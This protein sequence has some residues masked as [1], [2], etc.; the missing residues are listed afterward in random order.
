MKWLTLKTNSMGTTLLDLMVAL[1]IAAIIFQLT[2]TFYPSFLANNRADNQAH[3]LLRTLNYSR[4]YAIENNT[5]VTVCAIKENTCLI[6][7]WQYGFSAFVDNN[8][9]LSIDNGER[10]LITFSQNHNADQLKY[11]RDTI[12]FRP[13]GTINGLNNGTFTYCPNYKQAE[14]AGHALTVSQTGRI[15]L[16]STSKCLK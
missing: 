2:L 14:L 5:F 12:T 13:D 11:P 9:S 15:R 4:L 3:K 6:D 10:V 16:K 1:A 8:K 7:Q